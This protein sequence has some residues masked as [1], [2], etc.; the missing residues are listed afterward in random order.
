MRLLPRRRTQ[1]GVHRARRKGRQAFRRVQVVHLNKG[2]GVCDA[3]EECNDNHESYFQWLPYEKWTRQ[4]SIDTVI[5]SRSLITPLD[6]NFDLE[7]ATREY[8][9][10]K[11]SN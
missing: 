1:E 11:V 3:S 7:E 9:P 8:Y 4:V 6:S 2:R 10:G 5:S